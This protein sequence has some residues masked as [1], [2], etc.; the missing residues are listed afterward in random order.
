M[1]DDMFE[2]MDRTLRIGASKNEVEK[3]HTRYQ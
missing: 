2:N 3:Y 1:E